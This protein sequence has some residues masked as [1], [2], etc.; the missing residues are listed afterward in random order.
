VSDF[1]ETDLTQFAKSIVQGENG[2]YLAQSRA[3][4]VFYRE[5]FN[6]ACFAVE[7]LSFWFTA[8]N[9]CLTALRQ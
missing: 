2:I 7:G 9:L 1:K 6:N 8:R 4:E 3:K 5:D